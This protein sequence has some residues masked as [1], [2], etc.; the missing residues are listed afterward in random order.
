MRVAR[1]WCPLS[2]ICALDV[3]LVL[4]PAPFWEPVSSIVLP[5]GSVLAA[6]LVCFEDSPTV[7]FNPNMTMKSLV[8]WRSTDDGKHPTTLPDNLGL[9]SKS[10]DFRFGQV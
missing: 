2:I 9:A 6:T 4:R 8:A 3:V 7:P 10:A 1:L 5:D